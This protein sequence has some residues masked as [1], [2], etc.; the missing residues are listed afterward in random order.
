MHGFRAQLHTVSA[1]TLAVRL[2]THALQY[3]QY[4]FTPVNNVT[5]EDVLAAAVGHSK[6]SHGDANEIVKKKKEQ[7]ILFFWKY[8]YI[9]KYTY[10]SLFVCLFVFAM[11]QIKCLR[12]SRCFCESCQCPF[13]CNETKLVH[14]DFCWFEKQK[15]ADGCW[16]LFHNVLSIHF[17]LK[18]RFDWNKLVN[19]DWC[20]YWWSSSV[21]SCQKCTF[22]AVND[23]YII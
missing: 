18:K 23:D 4:A 19:F 12:M 16:S 13:L 9:Y 17:W 8:I 6:H 11:R 5:F 20:V 3:V 14:K 1:W 21:N 2:S 22:R 10:C 7:C 15:K